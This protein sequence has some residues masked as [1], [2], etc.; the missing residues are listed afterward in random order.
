MFF[1]LREQIVGIYSPLEQGQG[2]NLLNQQQNEMWPKKKKQQ[3]EKAVFFYF[4][5]NQCRIQQ[6]KMITH[7][8]LFVVD[9]SMNIKRL[10]LLSH[11][12]TVSWVALTPTLHGH[13]LH[14]P[15]NST[16]QLLLLPNN[17][18]YNNKY[19]L[20]IHIYK[21]IWFDYICWKLLSFYH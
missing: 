17:K 14:L 8:S 10:C 2:Q 19:I 16:L 15:Y 13:M 7:M 20:H 6:S 4:F 12:F 3:N 21:S 18:Y 1:F 9:D 5:S 11:S